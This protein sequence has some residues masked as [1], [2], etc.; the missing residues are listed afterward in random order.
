MKVI[1]IKDVESLGETG[2]EIVVKDGYARNCLIPKKLAVEPTKGIL[3]I[4]E[5]KEREKERRE[6]L[7]KEENERLAEKITAT[8]CTIS[9]DA[10]EGDKLFGSVTSEMIAENLRVEG[11]D[12]DRRKIILEEPIKALGVYNVE[13]QLHPEVKT[14]VRV[15]VVKK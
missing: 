7:L 12:I 2:D 6:K 11:V 4:L 14:Q 1:L 8:S 5:R 9:V 10:G 15:W 13:V 3:R